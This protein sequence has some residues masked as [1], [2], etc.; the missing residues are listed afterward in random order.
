MYIPNRFEFLQNRPPL[1]FYVE[2]PES[3][4]TKRNDS[5]II[6][7]FKQ[8]ETFRYVL[9][10]PGEGY[11][12]FRTWEALFLRSI[13]IV[14]RDPVKSSVFENLP[15]WIYDD[16]MGKIEFQCLDVLVRILRSKKID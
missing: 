6:G 16:L 4:L 14:Q 12:C 3:T 1:L 2:S 5:D 8:L 15:V 10:P 7:Y 9:S 11:D 13:P